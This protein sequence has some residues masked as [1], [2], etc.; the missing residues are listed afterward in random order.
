MS[1]YH[2][3]DVC[4]FIFHCLVLITDPKAGILDIPTAGQKEHIRRYKAPRAVHPSP[5]ATD[6]PALDFEPEQV[7]RPERDQKFPPILTIDGRVDTDI[8]HLMDDDDD[9]L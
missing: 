8:D 4:I 6:N 5:D 2:W 3:F 7:P 9:G 1:C